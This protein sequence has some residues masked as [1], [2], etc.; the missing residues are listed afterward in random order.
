MNTKTIRLHCALLALASPLCIAADKGPA[1]GSFGFNWLRPKS[2]Q[3]QAVSEA[4]LKRFRRCE[5][6]SGAFGLDDPVYVCRA[7]AG[8]EYMIFET[9]SACN[10]N[11][12]TMKAN[13]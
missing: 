5:H 2:A 7:D 10:E 13:E 8:T 1:A 11:L 12:E 9:R 3:C 4:L 6:Q